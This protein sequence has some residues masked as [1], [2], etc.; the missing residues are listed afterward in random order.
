MPGV[1][2]SGFMFPIR[3][4]PEP[5]QYATVLNPLRW[6]L[7]IM[8]GMVL[9]GEGVS[10]LWPAIAWQAGLAFSFVTLAVARFRKTLS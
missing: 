8:R 6:F 4:M 5:V 2:L 9:K 3:N 1:L 10:T 7:V